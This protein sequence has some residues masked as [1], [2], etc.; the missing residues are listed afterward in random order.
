MDLRQFKL[1]NDEEIICEVVEWNDDEHDTMVVRGALKIIAIDDTST[2]MRYYT[3]KPWM[4]MNN[5]PKSLQV[6]NSYHIVSECAPTQ[7]ATQH[8]NDVIKEMVIDDIEE[9]LEEIDLK[10]NEALT[11][12]SIDADTLIV[13]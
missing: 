12:D 7:I 3:F 9:Q 10:I 4:M 13:H 11:G 8:Y 1:T 6:L 2:A 5:D